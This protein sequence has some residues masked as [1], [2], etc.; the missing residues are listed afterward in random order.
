MSYIA[1]QVNVLLKRW[2]GDGY[3]SNIYF[4]GGV[5]L[6]KYRDYQHS[7]ILSEIDADAESRRCFASTKLQSMLTGIGSNYVHVQSRL[8]F[9][10]YK[11]EFN[12]VSTWFMVQHDFNS[13]LEK[14]EIL[15]PLIRFYYENYLFEAGRSLEGDWML[16]FMVHI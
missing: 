5:G 2:N 9:A 14:K 16:N 11:A 8:G 13:L 7:S 15:T 4:M 10:P 6:M 12:E 1:P 3:Q